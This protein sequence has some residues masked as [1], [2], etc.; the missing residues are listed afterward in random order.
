MSDTATDR[1]YDIAKKFHDLLYVVSWHRCS[2]C[3]L[4]K[5][6][7]SMWTT[8]ILVLMVNMKVIH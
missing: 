5:S 2:S 3:H 7:S 6:T 8:I 4:K 1:V